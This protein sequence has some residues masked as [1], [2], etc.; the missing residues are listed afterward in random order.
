[1]KLTK[2]TITGLLTSGILLGA[3]VPAHAA[4]VTY[5]QSATTEGSVKFKEGEGTPDVVNPLDPDGPDVT[6]V[7]PVGTEG[8][9]RLDQ[10]PTLDFGTVEIKG[11]EVKSGAKYV[12]LNKAGTEDVAFYTP[13]YIQLTDQRGNNGGWTVTTKMSAFTA[14]EA[15]VPV[16]GVET[17]EGA[18]VTFKNGQLTNYSGMTGAGLNAILPTAYSNV[19]LSANNSAT[20]KKLMGA[21]AG[22]GTGTWVN[23]FYDTQGGTVTAPPSSQDGEVTDSSIELAIPGTAKKSKDYTYVST[24]T[25]T[26]SSTPDS[27]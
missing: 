25:W 9:L 7:P 10:V 17:L 23:N 19:V 3:V 26:V 4:D 11:S 27:I 5:P 13:A 21:E 1:M 22:K 18:T 16:A 8:L 6:P 20:D 14:M 12:R 15:D 24:I 2:L